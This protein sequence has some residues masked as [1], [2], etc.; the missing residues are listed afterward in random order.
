MLNGGRI[1]ILSK[2][3]KEFEVDFLYR[4]IE[5]ASGLIKENWISNFNS[6]EEECNKKGDPPC[7]PRSIRLKMSLESDNQIKVSSSQVI[8]LCIRPCKPEIFQ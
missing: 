2:N 6:S 4:E 7:L 1:H 3:V 8:N 5:Q